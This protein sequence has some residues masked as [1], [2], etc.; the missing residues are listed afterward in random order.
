M[1]RY[2]SLTC[3][4]AF[5]A[6]SLSAQSVPPV[7]LSTGIIGIAAAQTARLN[8]L[9]VG[10]PPSAVGLTCTA[11]V[12]FLDGAGIVLKS[13]TLTIAPGTSMGF[14]VRSDTDLG[15][16]ALGDRREIRATISIPALTPTPASS[17]AAVPTCRL[18]PTLEMFN[19]ITG[20][21]QVVL[22]HVETIP[23]VPVTTT[24]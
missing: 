22:G 12:A 7:T 2:A 6:T 18:I 13:T 23:V 15:L 16:L 24:P 14:D 3:V 19:S 21:T 20:Q 9:N 10:A 8:L 11:A 4:L 1:F 17:T 5:G